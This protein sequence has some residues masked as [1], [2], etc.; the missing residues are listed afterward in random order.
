MASVQDIKITE[1]LLILFLA[2]A[3]ADSKKA[4]LQMKQC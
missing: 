3:V 4:D 2:V 1:L